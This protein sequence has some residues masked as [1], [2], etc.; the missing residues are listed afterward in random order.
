MR[1]TPLL[2]LGLLALGCDDSAP[3]EGNWFDPQDLG[4]AAEVDGGAQGTPDGVCEPDETRCVDG[5]LR[6][7][8][9]DATGW[10]VERCGEASRCVEGACQVLACEPGARRCGDAGPEL[11]AA[12]GSAWAPADACAAS[13]TCIEGVC[14]AQLCVPGDAACGEGVALT[15]AADGLSWDRSPCPISERCL[16]G[17]CQAL[18]V[19]GGVQCPAGEVLCGPR[20]LYACQE[21]GESW[22]ETPCAEGEA[23]FEGRCVQ[24]VRD[25]DCGA[26][27][28]TDGACVA[29]PL[30]IATAELP[31]GQ[32][33]VAYNAPL[34]A[35]HGA[36][37][38]TWAL[39]GDVPAGLAIAD[40]ALAGTPQA[41][42]RF[43]LTLVVTDDAGAEARA[44]YTLP[45][46]GDGLEILTD[47]LPEA[48][49]G[50]AYAVDFQAG[51]GA[52]P[53]GWFLVDGALPAGLNLAANGALRGTPSEIGAFDFTMRA[54]DADTPP[55]FAE[56]DFTLQVAIAPLRI[57]ADQILELFVTR[58]VTL[59]TITVVPNIPIPY[60]T[61][62][63]AAGGL[64]PYHWVETEL[65]DGLRAFIPQSGLPEGLELM[66][67]GTVQGAVVSLDQL[68]ELPIPFTEIVLTGFF[69]F[70]E[71]SDDQDPPAT[72]SAIFMLPTLP[73]GN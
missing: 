27:V 57:V 53:Y 45:I 66:E 38:Y 32:V 56:R 58:V 28:C 35:S 14:L 3:G 48:Q 30:A 64:R 24:C 20:G 49:E 39:E 41:A 72:Q 26:G 67:D 73:I 68:V 34:E 12:D 40:A 50:D 65:P 60:V 71:V 29:A 2:L 5:L 18:P 42:G 23:C 19:T 37:P 52:A 9:D 36:P 62:L 46:S 54:V 13:E 55:S 47:G 6:T 17:V 8:I 69:F 21:D 44:D 70:A 7:C 16:D 11:C 22:V 31:A 15:C 4:P 25:R 10:L 43:A 51:G 63:Q 59:P 61:N 1:Y 33:G